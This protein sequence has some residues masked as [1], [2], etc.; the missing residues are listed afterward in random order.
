[1]WAQIGMTKRWESQV[2]FAVR[3]G[4]LHSTI[5]TTA[6]VAPQLTLVGFIVLSVKELRAGQLGITLLT[7]WSL[8]VSP[9]Q[10]FPSLK[11]RWGYSVLTGKDQTASL[12]TEWA[13]SENL[14][15]LWQRLGQH[16]SLSAHLSFNPATQLHSALSTS[17]PTIKDERLAAT[18]T[19]LATT[20][21]IILS[22]ILKIK[23]LKFFIFVSRRLEKVQRRFTRMIPCLRELL[24]ECRL[25]KL[26]LWSLESRRIR[27]DLIEVYK[28]FHG[29][30]TI[31]I[32][33]LFTLD[34]EVTCWN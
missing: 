27:A 2:R 7:T 8:A 16:I 33:N 31:D 4:Y 17:Q 10:E 9:Q 32:S 22:I 23:Y 20:I 13:L 11:S 6:T 26:N 34:T 25:K 28:M 12:L 30:S 1:V 15:C 14:D 19:D 29:L 24:Y 18:I 3:V 5:H 21:W